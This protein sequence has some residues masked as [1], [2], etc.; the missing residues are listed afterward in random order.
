MLT[1]ASGS[2]ASGAI[3]PTTGGGLGALTDLASLLASALAASR[4]ADGRDLANGDQAQSTGIG[5]N[6]NDL[7]ARVATAAAALTAALSACAAALPG[8]AAPGTGAAPATLPTTAG[9]D[10]ILTALTQ[11]TLLGV[12]GTAP[13]VPGDQP[14]PSELTLL[15]E[16]TY[17]A[18]RILTRRQAAFDAITDDSTASPAHQL[19][20]ALT[21]LAAIFG[22]FT[23]VPL[24]PA[25]GSVLT[26]SAVT[27]TAL[28]PGQDHIAWLSKIAHLRPAVADL[29]T[30]LT[31]AE[32]AGRA[33]L[34]VTAAQLPT[35]QPW[36]GGPC[37]AST[38][39]AGT[40]CLTLLGAIPAGP[41]PAGALVLGDWTETI[42]SD[43]ETT[44]ITYQ[45]DSPT[46]QAPQTVLIAVPPVPGAGWTYQQLADTVGE[47]IDLAYARTVD[48]SMA[49]V[50]WRRLLPAIYL[51]DTPYTAPAIPARYPTIDI[52][53][54]TAIATVTG[55]SY[56]GQS[57]P[58]L[59]QGFTGQLQISGLDLGDA[60]ASAIALNPA[61]NG[62]TLTGYNATSATAGVLS[63]AITKDASL[64]PRMMRA[65]SG[66]WL[67]NAF[68]VTARPS[69]DI[70]SPTLI[71]QQMTAAT[72]TV[73]IAGQKLGGADVTL[74]P[75]GG[76]LTYASRSVSADQT[77]VIVTISVSAST[78]DPSP[79]EHIWYDDNGKPHV[80]QIP[81]QPP[82]Y[83]NASFTLTVS[84]VG[85]DTASF[86]I[87][88]RE[89][90]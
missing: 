49:P 67:T 46:A 29:L 60:D 30:A 15:A 61:G 69:A 50:P 40:L 4:P 59:S 85:G 87:F 45:F 88:L 24:Q 51:A 14:G 39:D 3:L 70:V 11:A 6:Q 77:A 2:T 17:A 1:L 47:T 22:T 43:A 41:A 73:T 33:R 34:T 12:P 32:A 38:L 71:S 35:G 64:G 25:A 72:A 63:V 54:K 8:V 16:Q 58:Q 13:A 66:T 78:Y 7:D 44:A 37:D 18:W 9:A 83:S 48:L 76:P 82:K 26:G 19:T 68:A 80:I 55:V 74:T 53:A 27:A 52:L 56:N 89:I 75:T 62:V 36:A 79:Q 65:G 42:P 28:P 20:A 84:P 23:A 90:T 31:A 81:A 86:V 57:Q 5:I 21:R 10:A